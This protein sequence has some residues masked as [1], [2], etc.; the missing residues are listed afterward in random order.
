MFKGRQEYIYWLAYFQAKVYY[1]PNVIYMLLFTM[2]EV[3][4]A[5]SS[6]QKGMGIC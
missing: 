1:P 3:G 2:V 4:Q 5:G 6:G